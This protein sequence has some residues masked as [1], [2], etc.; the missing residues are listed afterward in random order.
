MK[1]HA[2]I[3]LLA[4]TAGGSMFGIVGAFLAVPVAAVVAVVIRYIG[5]QVDLK[6]DDRDPDAGTETEVVSEAVPAA[7]PG[8]LA[9]AD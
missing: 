3:V 5:E 1:L 8:D 7:E 2:V 6:L 4:V 9:T